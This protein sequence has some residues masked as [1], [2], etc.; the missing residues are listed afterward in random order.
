[1]AAM[2]AQRCAPISILFYHRVADRQLNPWT[3]SNH[4]FQQH[5]D[6]LARGFEFIGLD[7]VQRRMHCKDSPRPAVSITFDDGY[8]EN[9]RFA[10]P[11]LIRRKI[12]VTYFV[13]LQNVLQGKP[14]PHDEVNG[15]PLPVNTIDQLRSLA[16]RGIEI[17]AHTR[18]HP[19]L[20]RIADGPSLDDEI[21]Q[22]SG[23]LGSAIGHRIRFFAVPFGMPAQL[24]KS[25][26]SA[27]KRGG[28]DG[29]CS[30]Y[31]DYNI[32]GQD[33]DFHLRRIH[34]DPS[35]V[36]LKNW[37]SFDSRKRR[38]APHPVWETPRQAARVPTS[39]APS[40]GSPPATT[41]PPNRSSTG[42]TFES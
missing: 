31:G 20:G 39:I 42:H 1:M 3:I 18:T 19:D 25:V 2:A 5:I 7:E 11:M 13:T 9:L 34:G 38:R 12:P 17:G 6:W 33:D 22:A 26:Y 40:A 8:A 27:V 37:V 10:L 41:S 30:A 16:D 29:F 36:R 21:I 23:E 4:R 32:P 14:F 15:A 24:T 35:L 28:F